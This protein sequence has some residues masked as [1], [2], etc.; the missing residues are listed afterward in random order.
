MPDMRGVP[1]PPQA[2]VEADAARSLAE[3]IQGGDVTAELL[4]DA[5]ESGY[6]VAKE[7]AWVCGRPWFDACFRQLDPDVELHWLVAEG[8]EVAAGTVLVRFRG[9][10]R[11]LVG[12]ERSA[13]NF[14][15]TLSATATQTAAYAKALAGTGTRVLDTR[16]TLPGLRQAQ[17]YA[18]RVGGGINHR[19]GLF[20]AVM[21]KENHIHAA[22]S[23]AAAV[24]E[25]RSR[26]PDIPVIVEVETLDELREA[27][28]TDCT[29]ILIDDFS[30]A[31]MHEA[32]RLAGG[33][34]PL[35]VSGGVTWERLAA[36][37]AAGVDFVSVGALT[38]HIRAVD[39]SMRLGDPP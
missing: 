14:L 24:A 36:I 27:L 22:G 15:Q 10:V 11:A 23:I 7:A 30:D 20:D 39:F 37:A 4:E 6:V 19:M 16:K 12:A 34:K 3:D 5:I 31:D 1:A 21:L 13:L 38:K 17:K 9:R 2:V 33:R 35:E 28:A 25:S 18:V 8:D 29:R 26:H 32:V